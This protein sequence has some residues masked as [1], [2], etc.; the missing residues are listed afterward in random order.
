MKPD[1]DE[2]CPF[3]PVRLQT[4]YKTGVEYKYHL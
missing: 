1:D 2:A 4:A 3:K